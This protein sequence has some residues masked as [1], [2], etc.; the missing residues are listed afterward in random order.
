M[1]VPEERI[2]EGVSRDRDEVGLRTR[3]GLRS[4]ESELQLLSSLRIRRTYPYSPWTLR[5]ILG[6]L[7]VFKVE[8][9][10]VSPLRGRGRGL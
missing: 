8:E 3:G 10:E 9:G 2:K 6:I 4:C 5:E 1:S 7:H